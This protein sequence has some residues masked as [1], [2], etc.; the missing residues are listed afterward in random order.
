MIFL[1]GIF[2]FF[3]KQYQAIL[4]LLRITKLKLMYP[5]ATIDYK[6]IIGAHCDI[7]CVKGG[8]LHISNC[9]I[10]AGTHIFADANST[11]SM[12]NCFIGR[13]CVVTA[14]E[15]VTI[16]PGCLIAEMVV[17]RDQDH[18][19]ESRDNNK[20]NEGFTTAPVCIGE[21]VWLASKATVLKGVTVGT[22]AVI[23]A[24]AVVTT[25]IPAWELWGGIPAK[26]IKKIV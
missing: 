26:F 23:A 22:G 4:N 11:L 8:K 5:G 3:F 15:S 19:L 21:N 16:M 13:N 1:S 10:K 20:S 9:S 17:I 18:I 25:S 14:K 24:S 2:R 7:V 6:T 12:R